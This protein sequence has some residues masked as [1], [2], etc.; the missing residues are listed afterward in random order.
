MSGGW[1]RHLVRESF[2]KRGLYEGYEESL[3]H[4]KR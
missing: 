3:N 1:D 2:V 4:V